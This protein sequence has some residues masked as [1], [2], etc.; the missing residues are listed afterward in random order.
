MPKHHRWLILL[1]LLGTP[2]AAPAPAHA[3]DAFK[4]VAH[5]EVPA[6]S[7]TRAELSQLFLKRKTSWGAGRPVRP[8]DQ[9]DRSPTRRTFSQAV[10]GKPTESIKSFWQQQ[11][12]SGRAVPPPEKGS[13]DEVL[14]F[15]R[16]TPG[17]VGYVSRSAAVSGVKV[18]MVTP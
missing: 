6:A 2:V 18:V 15:V 8:V 4:V 1:G 3:Q 13:D 7:V 14:A 16:A 12:F 17:A 11:I 5:P 9:V 10:H